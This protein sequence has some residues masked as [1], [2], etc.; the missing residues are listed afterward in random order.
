MSAMTA[1]TG[2][3]H[4]QS[5]FHQ[6]LAVDAFRVVL[7]DLVLQTDITGGSLLSF[8]VALCAE[9]GN[10]R[11]KSLRA[12]IQLPENGMSAVAFLARRAVGIILRN[13]YAVSA[14]L[15]LLTHFSM[16]GRTIDLLR[17]RFTRT[18][19]RD[20]HFR[21]ALTAGDLRVSREAKLLPLHVQ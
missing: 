6:T 3:R 1:R 17:D 15:V 21:V 10:I 8:P 11:R 13:E 5:A 18:N 20:T 14:L 12:R 4:R 16:A 7:D 19:V 2:C 9:Q